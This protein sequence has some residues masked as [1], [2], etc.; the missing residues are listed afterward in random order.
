M[1]EA[2]KPILAKLVEGKDLSSEDV[3]LAFEEV[4]T[5][6]ATPAQIGALLAALRLKGETW[7]EIAEAARVMRRHALTVPHRLPQDE[8]LVDTCGTGGDQKGTFNVS[9]ATAFV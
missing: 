2:L 5:G 3:Q 4:I 8:P 9:T 1:S 6:H 7:E